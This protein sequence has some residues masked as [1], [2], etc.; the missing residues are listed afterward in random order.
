MLLGSDFFH[1]LLVISNACQ[2]E[3]QYVYEYVGL[4]FT[5]YSSCKDW[6]VDAA[7]W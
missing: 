4:F 2:P 6:A 3:I 5:E 1:L 7:E